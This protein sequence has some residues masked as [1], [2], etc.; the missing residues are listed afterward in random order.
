VKRRWVGGWRYPGLGD[1]GLV[2]ALTWEDG[3][4]GIADK[5]EKR[6]WKFVVVDADGDVDVDVV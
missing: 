4:V 5:N 1:C 6:G 2:A 3:V